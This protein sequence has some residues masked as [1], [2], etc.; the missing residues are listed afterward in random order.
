MQEALFRVHPNL[1]GKVDHAE[2]STPLTTRHFAGHPKG[3]LH[4]IDHTPARYD[5]P[6]RAQSPVPG[7]FLT[8]AD[9]VSCGVS[10][11]LV[12]GAITTGAILGIRTLGKIMTPPK[13][14]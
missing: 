6:L 10:A 11:A 3:E 8:G 12:G 1:R 9:L 2:L 5:V 14:A 4:G 7:L 13:R